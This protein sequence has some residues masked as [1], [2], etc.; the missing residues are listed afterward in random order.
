MEYD[1]LK[2]GNHS[3]TSSA[4]NLTFTYIVRGNRHIS[5][6]DDPGIIDRLV[7]VQCPGWGLG[8]TYLQ[9][10]LAPLETH[11]SLL[12]FHP[13]GTGGSEKP[14]NEVE[15]DSLT[16]A[17]DIESL[18][19]H[20]GLDKFPA[21]LGH[22]NG[23]T[24]ALAYAEMFPHRVE[25]L[26]LLNHRLLGLELELES[27]NETDE[28]EKGQQDFAADETI[29]GCPRSVIDRELTSAWVKVLHR[30]FYDPAT[31][32]PKF[33]SAMGDTLIDSW[34]LAKQKTYDHRPA[35][36]QWMTAHLSDVR[37]SVL[38]IFGKQDNICPV[39]NAERTMQDVVDAKLV[40]LDGCGH[41]PWIEKEAETLE[42]IVSFLRA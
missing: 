25:K 17:E 4:N 7:L 33:T 22:S 39:A 15:M 41:F 40:L 29:P 16:M 11:F 2:P 13:R 32:L 1:L 21:M 20:L 3:F 34:C 18:R 5:D 14:G 36:G 6:S 23:G 26:V 19:S 31:S 8:S 42:K 38:L 28:N 35:V 30:Y 24:I 12:F 9:A 27:S 10:G 37:A